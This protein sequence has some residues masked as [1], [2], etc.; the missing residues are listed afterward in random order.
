MPKRKQPL[1]RTEWAERDVAEFL[2]LP[3]VREFVFRSPQ[4]LDGTQREVADLLIAHGN[5]G[6]LISQKCQEDPSSR[7]ITKTVLWARKEAKNA[8]S[9]LR[10]A[11]RAP[12]AKAVWCNHPRRGRVEFPNGL[13]KID[14]G[15][16]LVE[17]FQSVDLRSEA[18][19]LPLDFRGTPISYF[20]VNDFLN[21][22]VELRTTP[23]L[24][25]YLKARRSLP[26]SDL[27]TI[28]DERS[29]FE[30]YLL[31]GGS[32]RGCS[33]RADARQVARAN[34]EQLRQLLR[35]KADSK[36]HSMLLEHVADQLATRNPKYADDIP[37]IVLAKFDP[38]YGRTAYLEMQGVLANLRL[39]ERIELGCEFY[40]LIERRHSEPEGFVYR[41]AGLASRPDWVFVFGSSKM[42]SRALLL[43]RMGVLMSAAMTFFVKRCCMAVIDRDG[44]AYEVGLGRMESTPTS[45]EREAG[46]RLFAH[47]QVAARELSPAPTEA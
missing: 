1:R 34:R 37:E 12:L 5:L 14:H 18:S 47:L 29:L 24:L 33:S 44:L 16:V 27:R 26:P 9:Q 30:F 10:G 46:N 11:L 39:A 40:G 28:G 43:Q 21:L 8:V 23:E 7:S 41:A 4:T 19:A 20:S 15:V 36:R 32:L 2:S 42:L 22:A 13:P 25:E 31:N 6:I 3:L 38:P 35:S 17:V 45:A